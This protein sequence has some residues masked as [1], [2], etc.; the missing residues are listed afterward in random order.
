MTTLAEDMLEQQRLDLVSILS[1]SPALLSIKGVEITVGTELLQRA[2]ESGGMGSTS[3]NE[4]SVLGPA[5]SIKGMTIHV[6]DVVQVKPFG[7]KEWISC[8][9]LSFNSGP[10]EFIM[11]LQALSNRPLGIDI[12][13]AG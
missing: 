5:E 11:T 6:S 4:I 12:E 10:V 7:M 3:A 9:I 13:D 1:E 2:Q 8:G